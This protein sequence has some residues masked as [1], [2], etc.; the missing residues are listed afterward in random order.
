MKAMYDTIIN[1]VNLIEAQ[2][3]VDGTTGPLK[4]IADDPTRPQSQEAKYRTAGNVFNKFE[5]IIENQ[6]GKEC[7]GICATGLKAF[8]GLTQYSNWILNNGTSEQ[9]Q[10]LLIGK[11]GQG[12]K[13]GNKTYKTLANIRSKDPNTIT[14]A[15]V[16]EAL[17]NVT[18]DEDAALV[19]SA[20][21][22]LSTDFRTIIKI[23]RK[24]ILKAESV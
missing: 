10:R 1:P 23:L 22:S 17:S 5:S 4:K 9:Q 24:F 3:S 7:I 6:V 15:D 13:I 14:N 16:L 20:L 18:N 11:N 21:L 19:L 2:T 8:F 12:Y